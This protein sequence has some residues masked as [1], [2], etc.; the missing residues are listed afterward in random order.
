MVK[1]KGEGV[2]EKFANEFLDPLLFG[3]AG[4][5]LQNIVDL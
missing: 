1:G 5:K 3:I 2:K 4:V